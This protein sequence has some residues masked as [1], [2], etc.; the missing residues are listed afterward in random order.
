[1]GVS[2]AAVIVAAGSSRRAGF[3]KLMAPLGNGSVLKKSFD[4]FYQCPAIGEI[5]LVTTPE[6]FN[7]VVPAGD[8]LKIP[9]HYVEG[10]ADRHHSVIAG[11]EAIG[12][13]ADF[14][15]VHDGARPLLNPEQLMRCLEEAVKH[16]ASASARPVVDTLKRADNHG[17]SLPEQINRASLWSM[18][19][20]QTFR[21]EELR[22]AYRIV[23][24]R[25]A[26]VTD[27][28]SAM[29]LA[30]KR[31]FLV[32]NSWPNPKITLP[33]DLAVAEALIKERGE[34]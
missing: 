9:V 2:F 33:G 6:R 18:E 28:V 10:G 12:T 13:G 7:A 21:L 19:T 4:V 20:P 17:F 5:V 32:S 34:A 23:A 30:G 24:E 14:V 29:E 22:A 3:D 27:E 26:V 11:L 15:A 16:G 31:T 25:G 8:E 1:M